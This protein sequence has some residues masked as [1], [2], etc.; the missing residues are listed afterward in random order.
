ME[1]KMMKKSKFL[2]VLLFWVQTSAW[3]QTNDAGVDSVVY[4]IKPGDTLQQ[5]SQ[6]YMQLPVD[7]TAL[8][9]SNQLSDINRLSI[10]AELRIPR[11]MLKYNPSSAT[12]MGIA[13]ASPIRVN[14]KALSNGDMLREGAVID[15]PP[16]CN[17]ALLLEDG[18]SVRLPSGA[19]L[20]LTTLR[21]NLIESAPQVRLDLIKGRIELD[22]NKKGRTPTTPFEIHTPL[23]VMGV[24][25]TEFRVGF[26][27]DDS[28]AQV[29][30][31]EGIVQTQGS[32][33]NQ[34]KNITEGL[35]VPL[36][37]EG[38]ALDIEKLLPP[39][40]FASAQNTTGAPPS[41]VVQLSAIEQANYY[42][43]Q[44]AGTANFS[45]PS[46]REN[47]LAPEIFIDR[48]SKQATFY[49]LTSISNSGLMGTTQNYG[50]CTPAPDSASARCAVVFDAPLASNAPISFLLTHTDNNVTKPTVDVKNLRAKNG[51]FAIQGLAAGHYK[52]K[53]SYPASAKSPQTQHE[54]LVE[55]SG[56]FELITLLPN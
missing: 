8:Q 22:V 25:G 15:V 50:F 9:K 1:T 56:A 12:V 7:M 32:S 30:V 42:V 27:P 46:K 31:L 20:K 23:S 53:L 16:E 28:S 44:I 38:K 21:K 17:V 2:W 6:K 18:S 4:K 54:T 19:T 52:W 47:L 48:L 45:G 40:T 24:R 33:D 55:Q 36:S 11:H 43:A 34:A 37:S 13:C 39:P 26:S 35:G 41:F 51:R 3:A 14:D 29:E 49:Q 5:L 10:N